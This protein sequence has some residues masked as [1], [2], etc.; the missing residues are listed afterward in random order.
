MTGVM[1]YVLGLALVAGLA[2]GSELPSSP[3]KVSL[4][5][6]PLRAEQIARTRNALQERYVRS[7]LLGE[8]REEDIPLLDFLDAQCTPVSLVHSH[9]IIFLVLPLQ[10]CVP[11]CT[12]KKLILPKQKLCL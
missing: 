4:N 11:L 8:A 10:L 3:I 5:K 7:K 2:C 12:I 9:V 1:R 6:R